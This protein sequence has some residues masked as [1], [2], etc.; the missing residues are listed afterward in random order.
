MVMHVTARTR[1]F[2]VCL[3]ATALVALAVL[4]ACSSDD[5]GSSGSS[6]SS[7]GGSSGTTSSGGTSTSSGGSTS[8]SGGTGCTG[9]IL[10][11]TV[12]SLSDAQQNDF[13]ST[14]YAV[15]DDA[16]GSK[17]ECKALDRYITVNDKATCVAQRAPA[18][19]TIKVAQVLDCYK[20]A[21]KDACTALADNGVCRIFF[22]PPPGCGS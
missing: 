16:A 7:S 9:D 15:I 12:G 14:L 19:C 6:T 17:Y 4:A 2:S 10:Q 8:S 22:A 3:S 13:C 5:S 1:T 18:S 11:C 21:K 20:A